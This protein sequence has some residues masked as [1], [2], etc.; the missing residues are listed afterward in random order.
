M[1][2][3]LNE[4]LVIL[5]KDGIYRLYP[6][7]TLQNTPTTSNNAISYSQHSLTHDVQDSSIIDARIYESG[8]IV[9]LS[10]HQFLEVRGWPERDTLNDSSISPSLL[11]SSRDQSTDNG[12]S[13]M[14]GKGRV[15]PLIESGLERLPTAW[16]I[17]TPD[18]STSRQTEVL[19]S[20]GEVLLSIDQSDTQDQHFS[21]GPFSHITPSPS[22]RFMA[23]LT[24]NHPQKLYVVS[25][26]YAESLSEYDLSNEPESSPSSASSYSSP[27][28]VLW[29]GN[30]CV[31]LAWE[32]Y[33]V[34]VGPYGQTLR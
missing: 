22:G 26:N 9:L 7:S 33:L 25:S 1:G 23:L 17:L 27:K 19:M 3:T 21:H 16:C 13:A 32:S 14:H 5:A 29:C 6:I 28:S 12:T 24:L 8:M 10:S 30:N 4:S 11:T 18:Q 34:M 20:S 2:F 31:I 15:E